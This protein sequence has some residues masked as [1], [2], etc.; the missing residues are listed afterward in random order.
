MPTREVPTVFS[1]NGYVFD[2]YVRS[3]VEARFRWDEAHRTIVAVEYHFHVTFYVGAK[4]DDADNQM[5]FIRSQ[6]EAVGGSLQ[7]K[8]GKGIGPFE[9]NSGGVRDVDF[10]PA[11][12]LHTFDP[13]GNGITVKC[14]WSCV[15]V[16]PYGISG[17]GR[18]TG[19]LMAFNYEYDYDIDEQ[20]LTTI[21]FSG[22]LEIPVTRR[23][24][25]DKTL[26]DNADNYWDQINY[27]SAPG[28]KRM[29]Q[30]RK[31]SKSKKRLDFNIQD[32]EIPV[33]LPYN[34]VTAE[35]THRISSNLG[36]H[37][38]FAVWNNTISG[39]FTV[40][41]DKNKNEAWLKAKMLI[42][43]RI[44][45]AK[46]STK[47]DCVIPQSV[48]I[49]E[50][51]FTKQTN[52]SISYYVIGLATISFHLKA[53]GLWTT[54]PWNFAGY[55]RSLKSTVNA[56]DHRGYAKLKFKNEY[57]L[58]IDL[59][60]TPPKSPKI[61]P[62]SDVNTSNSNDFPPFPKPD[63]ANS[64]LYYSLNMEL[65][66]DDRVVRH[67]PMD[68]NPK[69]LPP[70]LNAML[71]VPEFDKLLID[72]DVAVAQPKQDIIQRVSDPSYTVI[73]SGRGIRVGY[74]ITTPRLAQLND[75]PL[76]QKFARER[77]RSISQYNGIGI[78]YAQWY[79][80]YIC[81]MD[82]KG[83]KI[84]TNPWLRLNGD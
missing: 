30:E 83:L 61:D 20:G 72:Q 78:N 22:Y 67:K 45:Q 16:I 74:D 71:P 6:L 39:S 79:I 40:A 64:W 10:G 44:L 29:R 19:A 43:N 32:R 13:V 51:I 4:D 12:E 25:A 3:K 75:I 23:N 65:I 80:E 77:Q 73:L 70:V 68:H 36:Q 37:R 21:T 1:Y 55:D 26:V 63:K 24:S 57:D 27:A 59:L 8:G 38:G 17:L 60:G 48:D 42:Q 15:A 2:G 35:A 14:E 84:P 56:N 58:I 81:P 52:F 62:D 33:A 31:L 28:Y 82:P 49:S 7:Y 11:P 46:R 18:T 41:P 66:E 9:V 34:M 50:N 5:A 54:L 53:S 76:T 69:P 47:K